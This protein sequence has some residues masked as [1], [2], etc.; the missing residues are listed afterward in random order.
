MRGAGPRA[1]EILQRSRLWLLPRRHL[2]D[3][4]VLKTGPKTTEKFGT[5][6]RVS[7]PLLHRH[8]TSSNFWISSQRFARG[9]SS[10]NYLGDVILDPV[11]ASSTP[12][13][14]MLNFKAIESYRGFFPIQSVPSSDH[15]CRPCPV[16]FYPFPPMKVSVALFAPGRRFDFTCP[17]LSRCWSG[18]E[19]PYRHRSK[20]KE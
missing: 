18:W 4:S 8:A 10:G 5:K 2:C 9:F 19:A 1:S 7:A 12:Y 15:S 17:S 3:S 20:E 16:P 6:Y 11:A 14:Y 13:G